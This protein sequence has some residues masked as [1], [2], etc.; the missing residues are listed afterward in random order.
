MTGRSQTLQW[1]LSRG[2]V[3]T[4]ENKKH[5][6][7]KKGI[8]IGLPES[9]DKPKLLMVFQKAFNKAKTP[10]RSSREL[11]I[12]PSFLIGLSESF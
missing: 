8:R 3:K 5:W 7:P 6:P 1:W 2:E 12:K 4:T 11:L 9:F 10:H